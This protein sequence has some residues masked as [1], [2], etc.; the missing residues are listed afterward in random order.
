M[1]LK[2]GLIEKVKDGELKKRVILDRKESKV[3]S[4]S[5]RSNRA[6]L[7]RL[8][9]HIQGLL[10]ELDILW[11]QDAADAKAADEDDFVSAKDEESYNILKWI[12]L[13]PR[14]TPAG[15]FGSQRGKSLKWK[16]LPGIRARMQQKSHT[17]DGINLHIFNT[18]L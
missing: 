6:V 13:R 9:D 12:V 10:D 8:T 16:L 1:L 11:D 15:A 3:T 17:V 2:F 14:R 5:S 7:P 4:A 18:T